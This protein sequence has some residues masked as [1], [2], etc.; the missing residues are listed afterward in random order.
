MCWYETLILSS[1]K[2]QSDCLMYNS[3]TKSRCWGCAGNFLEIYFLSFLSIE[4]LRGD[5]LSAACAHSAS[6]TKYKIER[7]MCHVLALRLYIV[8][9][10][11]NARC[12]ASGFFRIS[13]VRTEQFAPTMMSN[14]YNKRNSPYFFCTQINMKYELIFVCVKEI[15]SAIV[16]IRMKSMIQH[17][18]HQTYFP[19]HMRCRTN[20]DFVFFFCH[21][22]CFFAVI[23]TKSMLNSVKNISE[24]F[25][26]SYAM[27]LHDFVLWRNSSAQS[28][29]TNME[30]NK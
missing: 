16:I 5:L 8:C 4:Q 3:R 22:F 18:T 23:I 6:S 9:C 29:E 12:H 28:Y 27:L 26:H 20:P 7:E 15:D 11:L 14:K 10:V 24:P 21:D 30:R 1:G 17:W 25:S 2:P 13:H 19:C